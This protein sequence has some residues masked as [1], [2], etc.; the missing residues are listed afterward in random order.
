MSGTRENENHRNIPADIDGQL[1]NDFILSL[2][3]QRKSLYEVFRN[4]PIWTNDLIESH[5]NS[6]LQ[7]TLPR[8]PAEKLFMI[9]K[10]I[11]IFPELYINF[12]DSVLRSLYQRLDESGQFQMYFTS[13]GHIAKTHGSIAICCQELGDGIAVSGTGDPSR[14][15]MN[16]PNDF[17][18]ALI[19]FLERSEVYFAS[20]E[21]MR[22]GTKNTI[23]VC[24]RENK[25][26][27]SYSLFSQE[28]NF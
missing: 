4:S 13:A 20:T 2:K 18:D 23:L 27:D 11:M 14:I 22:F 25:F 5:Y 15:K 12:K 8:T 28:K 3:K 16:L 6:C 19:K 1:Y 26:F 21:A 24:L 9:V 17:K 10:D 7:D